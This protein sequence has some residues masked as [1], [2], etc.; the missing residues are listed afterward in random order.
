MRTHIV[1]T[2]QLLQGMELQHEE[3]FLPNSSYSNQSK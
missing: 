1:R 3:L 2:M